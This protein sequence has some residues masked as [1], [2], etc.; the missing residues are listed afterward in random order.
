MLDK[1]FKKQIQDIPKY[2]CCCCRKFL[3][4]DQ[5]FTSK[6]SH[7][8][9]HISVNNILCSFC[10]RSLSRSVM[11]CWFFVGNNICPGDIPLVLRDL[12]L[13][14]KR[15]ISKI[16]AFFTLVV[17]PCYP[18]GQF[19]QKGFAIHCM[20]DKVNVVS[21]LPRM[22]SNE[23]CVCFHSSKLKERSLPFLKQ[24]PI[25]AFHWLIDNNPLCRDVNFDFDAIESLPSCPPDS[26]GIQEYG[27]IPTNCTSIA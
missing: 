12:T 24:N 15:M 13:V 18:V 22:T 27:I 10:S 25:E 4:S 11:P 7:N 20:S 5:L 6:K 8:E 14:E 26:Y 16:N 3:F 23:C 17:L 2:T 1:N 21:Q 9:L 19:A